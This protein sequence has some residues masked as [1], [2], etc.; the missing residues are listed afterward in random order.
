[1]RIDGCLGYCN[2]WI[3]EAIWM[4]TCEFLGPTESGGASISLVKKMP[5]MILKFLWG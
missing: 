1:M 4:A 5:G 3:D 2:A